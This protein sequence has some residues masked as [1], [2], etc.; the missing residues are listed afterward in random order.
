MLSGTPTLPGQISF[1]AQIV[2]EALQTDEQ[3]LSIYINDSLII[4]TG[5]LPDWTAGQLYAQQLTATG[6][7][8]QHTWSDKNA[9]LVG[10]GLD[11]APDGLLSGTPVS[12]ITISFTA[13]V[14]DAAGDNESRG[15]VFTI[16]PAVDITSDSLPEATVGQAYGYQLEVDGGTGTKTWSDL[17]GDLAGTGLSLAADGMLSGTPVDSGSYSFTAHVEDMVGSQDERLFTLVIVLP[18][19]CGDVDGDETGPN[20]ADLTYL[21]DYFFNG[22]AAPPIMEAANVDGIVGPGGPADVG[23]IVYLVEYLFH[24]GPAP[25]CEGW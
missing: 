18:Y 19:I 9:D 3:V 4:Q 24:G 17:N 15:F 21:V 11:L 5:S 22:G 13:S 1:T 8:G 14:T 20:V 23:D 6:G 7:T 25:V 12:A 16:N 10:T 2:D